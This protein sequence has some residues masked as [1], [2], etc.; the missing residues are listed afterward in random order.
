MENM[1]PGII[2]II[3]IVMVVKSIQKSRAEARTRPQ[4]DAE[5]ELVGDVIATIQRTAPDFDGA[6]VRF[7]STDPNGIGVGSEAGVRFKSL[8]GQDYE[9]NYAAHGYSVSGKM[10]LTLAAEIT[11]HFGGECRRVCSDNF[12][13]GYKIVSQRQ[14]AA[15]QEKKRQ[16][17]S[18]KRL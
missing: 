11:R 10:A 16:E 8:K 3:V 18:L 5:R 14:L 15:E 17:D 1:L 13:V 4:N 9:Y 2:I 12:V 7:S 6:Y